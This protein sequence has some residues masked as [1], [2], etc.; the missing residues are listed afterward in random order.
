MAGGRWIEEMCGGD[1]F[2]EAIGDGES[3]TYRSH[4]IF[5]G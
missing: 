5:N 3:G 1:Q 2:I 4:W